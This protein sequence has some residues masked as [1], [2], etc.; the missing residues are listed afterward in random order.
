MTSF[1]KF[2][3]NRSDWI[4]LSQSLKFTNWI[5]E[6]EQVSPDEILPVAMNILISKCSIHVPLKHPKETRKSKFQ[7]EHRVLMRKRTKLSRIIL[8]TPQIISQLLSIEEQISSSHLKEKIHE[9]HVAVSKIKVD[10]KHFFRYA[11]RY[12]IC[13]QEVGPLL[14]PLNNTLTDNKYEMFIGKPI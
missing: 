11:K 12:S 7:K 3:F 2:D 6:L 10:P 9:E 8:H 5:Y 13:K 1:E 4:N 14:N